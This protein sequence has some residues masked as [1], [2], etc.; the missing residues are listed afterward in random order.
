M[1]SAGNPV[2]ITTMPRLGR[3]PSCKLRQSRALNAV[4][5]ISLRRDSRRENS[6][7]QVTSVTHSAHRTKVSDSD[8]SWGGQV[9]SACPWTFMPIIS[10]ETLGDCAVILDCYDSCLGTGFCG[11]C[12]RLWARAKPAVLSDG[13]QAPGYSWRF[14]PC[15]PSGWT[16]PKLAIH[17]GLI[18]L[19][20][21]TLSTAL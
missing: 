2:E 11:G 1:R 5:R 10:V 9:S 17:I 3:Q 12:G 15:S 20:A 13:W 7:L 19:W 6:D 21:S 8:R 16:L 4:A 14:P 18:G